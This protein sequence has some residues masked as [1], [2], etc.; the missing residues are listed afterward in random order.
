MYNVYNIITYSLL[1][2][3]KDFFFLLNEYIVYRI[4]FCNIWYL[5]SFQFPFENISERVEFDLNE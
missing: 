1:L 3:L 2:Y 5:K 4:V